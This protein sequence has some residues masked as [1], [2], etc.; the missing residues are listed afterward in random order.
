MG[1]NPGLIYTRG[2]RVEVYFAGHWTRAQVLKSRPD[3]DAYVLLIDGLEATRH[4]QFVRT[5]AG[6]ER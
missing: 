2:D 6:R 3:L 4:E 5:F 1:Y